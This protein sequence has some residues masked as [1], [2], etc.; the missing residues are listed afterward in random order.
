MIDSSLFLS[1]IFFVSF[2]LGVLRINAIC[3][4]PYYKYT[5]ISRQKL[6]WFNFFPKQYKEIVKFAYVVQLLSIVY[7]LIYFLVFLVWLLI[8][9]TLGIY[10]VIGLIL[11]YYAYFG[12]IVILIYITIVSLKESLKRR[13]RRIR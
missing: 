2:Y 9:N 11:N 5:L 7:L 6:H 1:M 3:R 10:N 13:R 8:I 4:P 12:G